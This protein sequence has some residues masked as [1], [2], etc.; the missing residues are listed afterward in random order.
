[1]NIFFQSATALD[2]LFVVVQLLS[3]VQLFA[4]PWTA[5]LQASLFFTV[6]QSLLKFMSVES[7][8]LSNHLILC[9]PLLCL[10]SF[11]ASWSFTM[12]HLFTSGGQNIGAPAS[13]LPMNIQGWFPLRLTGLTLPSKGLSRVFSTTTIWRHSFFGAQPSLWSNSHIHPYMTTG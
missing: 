5:A 13:V 9:C 12:S 8:M 10:Q 2:H 4:I 7:V 11:P 6:S 3:Y 1:M